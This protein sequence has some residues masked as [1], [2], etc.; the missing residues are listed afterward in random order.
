MASNG[1]RGTSSSAALVPQKRFGL[2]EFFEARYPE[3]VLFVRFIPKKDIAL[4]DVS[5]EGY[6]AFTA[7]GELLVHKRSVESVHEW[8]YTEDCVP[9]W[10]H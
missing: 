1:S 3:Y 8:I 9:V 7:D 4:Y 6:G 10:M 2:N 5:H